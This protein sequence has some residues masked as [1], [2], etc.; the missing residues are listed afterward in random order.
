MNNQRGGGYSKYGGGRGAPPNSGMHVN[1]HSSRGA[2]QGNYN[3][4]GSSQ[5]HN[6]RGGYQQTNYQRGASSYS[7]NRPDSGNHSMGRG[8]NEYNR[9][10]NTN[11]SNRGSYN[12]YNQPP[13]G[14]HNEPGS[15]QKPMSRGSYQ[16]RGRSYDNSRGGSYDNSRGGS[17][18]NSRGGYNP[19]FNNR[20]GY[21]Q[22]QQQQP[23]YYPSN[24]N[25]EYVPRPRRNTRWKN[26]ITKQEISSFF[27]EYATF[28]LSAKAYHTE[29]VAPSEPVIAEPITIKEHQPSN[30]PAI[31][32][33]QINHVSEE[34]KSVSENIH[35]E[36]VKQEEIPSVAT[37]PNTQ[38]VQNVVPVQNATPIHNAQPP[39]E[40]ESEENKIT[41]TNLPAAQNVSSGEVK[42]SATETNN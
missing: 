22:Q 8:Q 29:T 30:A 39:M 4:R 37:P 28:I 9:P 21:Q 16:P 18:E 20:G 40:A 42:P 1:P 26:P 5:D 24:M 23:G 17:Y 34:I 19:G 38:L 6:P 15:Y 32:P 2:P 3:M 13:H 14:G 25:S 35:R 31:V 10:P 33:P 12:N 36:E 27:S 11:M 41:S 7:Q